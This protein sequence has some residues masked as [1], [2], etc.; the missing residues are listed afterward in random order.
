MCQETAVRPI[1]FYY[2]FHFYIFS[3]KTRK[4]RRCHTL[5]QRGPTT[6]PFHK[7]QVLS[8]ISGGN[9]L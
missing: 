9:F 5:G 1:L 7:I 4:L 8:M 6:E 2:L 3:S